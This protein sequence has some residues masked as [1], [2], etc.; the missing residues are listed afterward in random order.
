MC[1]PDHHG[2]WHSIKAEEVMPKKVWSNMQVQ[3]LC[4]FHGLCFLNKVQGVLP[5]T[6]SRVLAGLWSDPEWDEC[7]NQDQQNQ[8]ELQ[9]SLQKNHMVLCPM[10]F[11]SL[12]C[13]QFALDYH[14]CCGFSWNKEKCPFSSFQEVINQLCCTY[15]KL[16][17]IWVY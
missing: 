9:H 5:G 15:N 12:E 16:H 14:N 11:L 1:Y 6:V 4:L 8:E 13:P 2:I 17:L 7:H 3:L 10:S